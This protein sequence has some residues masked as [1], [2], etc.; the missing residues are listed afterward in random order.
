MK[1]PPDQETLALW[2]RSLL[3]LTA[4]QAPFPWQLALFERLRAGEVVRALD[5]PT[6]LGKTSVM[7]LWL[8]ARAC[9]ARLPRRL[10]YVVDRR[11]V[12]DQAT[13]MAVRLRESVTGSPDLKARLGLPARREFPISTLRGQ[14]VDNREWLEDPSSP[15]IVIG[16]V[17]MVG[18]RLLFEGY[19]VSR[20]MRPYHAGLLGAD[21][22]VVLDEAHL[23]PPF[24]KLLEAVADGGAQF[25][26]QDEER[27]QT[28]PPFRLMSLSATGRTKS[29]STFGLT[30]ADMKPGTITRKRLDARK[31]LSLS[32]LDQGANLAE[33]LAR[34]AWDL[35]KASNQPIRC[36]VFANER[37]IA[38]EARKHLEKLART[39]KKEGTGPDAIDT[40]LLVGSRRIFERQ[41][42]ADNLK[43]LGFIAGT[44][45]RREAPAFLFATSAG[46][47]GI[48]LDA[49]HMVCDLVEW[50]RMV[51]RL[52]RVNRRGDGDAEVRVLRASLD[53]K[54]DPDGTRTARWDAVVELV[55]RLPSSGE[56]T[57]DAS[58]AALVAIKQA[59]ENAELIEKATTP[60]PLHPPLTRALVESWSMT[61]LEEHTG[62]PE[63]EPWLRGWIDGQEPTTTII[64]RTHLPVTS[65][66]ALLGSAERKVFFEAAGPHTAELLETEAWRAAEWLETRIKSIN[67]T[68]AKPEAHSNSDEHAAA[69]TLD[70]NDDTAQATVIP[71]EEPRRPLRPNEVVALIQNDDARPFVITPRFSD[72]DKR[73]PLVE[74]LAGATLWVDVRLGGLGASGDGVVSGLLDPESDRASDVTVAQGNTVVV[75][76]RIRRDASAQGASN[77]DDDLWRQ[78]ARIPIRRSEAGDE[79]E[80]L[81]IESHAGNGAETEE[82]RAVSA[83]RSQTLAEHEEWT[84]RAARE[85]AER[86]QLDGRYKQ[87][88]ARAA[89]LHDE[90]KKAARW[91]RAF[92]ARLKG[93]PYAKTTRHPNIEML[94]GYRHEFGSLPYAEMDP[95]V[96]DM[97]DDLRDLCL[98][99]IAAHHGRARPLIPTDGAD[100]PP[101]LLIERA[102][103]VALRFAK[104]EK[105]WGPWGLAW[106]ES[107]LRAADQ[108]ASR[109]NDEGK[110]DRG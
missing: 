79:E 9:G 106:W 25:G 26:P 2:L 11:A 19:G 10:V 67:G 72:D 104:L 98:H 108:Q 20:R 50:E 80:W 83:K 14:F 18:S 3:G 105:L 17:D 85:I 94:G 96:S 1:A 53:T 8:A 49:D 110:S 35:S 93:G 16:T 107:L 57:F 60:A 63:V 39:A 101:S 48:D 77:S 52:G 15:A 31:R 38:E 90:G 78:E 36:L 102:G 69:A 32:A 29:G 97:P 37:K 81:V 27:R 24:E 22:L 75:P 34:Q 28:I 5:I 41:D 103:Q 7:A 99:M 12:V 64:W 59:P 40:E 95:V 58:P 76:L 73:N 86:L 62:R 4:G 82:G 92:G 43:R 23:V 51:Q 89:R 84:E 13:E 56:G 88:L 45:G 44:E 21:T 87:V 30:E 68:T 74:R 100:A 61:S 65:D 70:S 46:E 54:S 6:G 42:A 71:D 109:E 66:G 33:A 55:G 47:V 91:Q